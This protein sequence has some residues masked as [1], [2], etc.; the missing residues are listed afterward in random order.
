MKYFISAKS[1]CLLI[2]LILM[3]V[4]FNASGQ[5]TVYQYRHVPS[6]KINEFIRRETTYWSQVAQKAVDNK[7]MSFWALLEKVGGYDLA[8]S[9]NYLFINTFPDIDKTGEVFGNAEKITGMRMADIET[10]SMSSTTSELFLHSEDWAQVANARPESDFRYVVMNYHNAT[11]PDSLITL[12]KK[13]WHPFIQKSMDAKQTPQKAWGNAIILYP[14]DVDMRA[15]SVSYDLF[16]TLQDALMPKWDPKVTFPT[17]GLDLISKL[18]I[19][20][21]ESVVYRIVKVI[22]APD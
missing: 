21:M 1:V 16:S 17:K 5:I 4:Q 12:E 2:A 10:N 9:S 18:R 22:S 11:M 6:D 19:N 14:S 3:L 8:N 20:K 7:T 15:T 13:Y